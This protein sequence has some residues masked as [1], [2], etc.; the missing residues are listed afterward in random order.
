MDSLQL[1]SIL[2]VLQL[3]LA[4]WRCSPYCDSSLSATVATMEVVLRSRPHGPGFGRQE[5]RRGGLGHAYKPWLIPDC[6]FARVV[7]V[8]SWLGPP[9]PSPRDIVMSLLNRARL[10]RQEYDEALRAFIRMGN[11][12]TLVDAVAD[13]D[14]LPQDILGDWERTTQYSGFVTRF[15]SLFDE[16][17]TSLSAIVGARGN[18]IATRLRTVAEAAQLE[19]KLR[20]LIQS[21]E[22]ASTEG[23]RFQSEAKSQS[24]TRQRSHAP[25]R[26][27]RDHEG[28]AYGVLAVMVGLVALC[29]SIA[30]ATLGVSLGF[31]VGGVVG[32]I[33]VLALWAT[34]RWWVTG[35]ERAFSRRG[36]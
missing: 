35:L 16:C 33:G 4:A 28:F 26:T 10:L 22:T 11:W 19:T 20:R 5:F 14:G 25:R 24:Q 29:L 3:D 9:G 18:P 21:L 8:S 27:F 13:L 23:L 6:V 2:S 32:V 17:S 36:R 15:G 34:R 7:G 30:I 1:G 12:A 31:E